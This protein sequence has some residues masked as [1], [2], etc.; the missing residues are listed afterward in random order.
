MGMASGREIPETSKPRG[1]VLADRKIHHL[2]KIHNTWHEELS[3]TNHEALLISRSHVD[4][5]RIG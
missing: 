5:L 3:S 4:P 1:G 2:H